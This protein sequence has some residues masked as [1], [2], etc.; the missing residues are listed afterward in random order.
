M[1]RKALPPHTGILTNERN[2]ILN[3]G[4]KSKVRTWQKKT[5]IAINSG[6]VDAAKEAA[7]MATSMID[8]ATRRNIYH[9]NWANRNKARLSKKVITLILSQREAAAAAPAE[10]VA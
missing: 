5:E 1:R 2:R 3:A 9:K 6:N 8:R 10:V 7:R 4:W